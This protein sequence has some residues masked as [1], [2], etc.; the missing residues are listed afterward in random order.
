[1]IA[2]E[3]GKTRKANL[4]LGGTT[5][6]KRS[7]NGPM[8]PPDHDGPLPLGPPVPTDINQKV[9]QLLH[10]H[11]TEMLRDHKDSRQNWGMWSVKRAFKF[12]LYFPL[13]CMLSILISEKVLVN[14]ILI[15]IWFN[16][17]LGPVG[18]LAWVAY[19]QPLVWNNPAQNLGLY[20]LNCMFECI[21]ITS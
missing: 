11:A 17:A 16:P 18:L 13:Y 12:D 15:H 2:T 3:A 21:F 9:N 20:S 14:T 8:E 6:T 10:H 5:S 4:E 7:Q 1:M 19:L